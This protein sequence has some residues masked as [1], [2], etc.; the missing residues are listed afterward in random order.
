MARGNSWKT[1]NRTNAFYGRPS[2]VI[3]KR[4]L[5]IAPQFKA[6]DLY[7]PPFTHKKRFDEEGRWQYV[8]IERN[9]SPTGLRLLDELLRYLA[10]GS[11]DVSAFAEMR[12][13][14]LNELHTFI[15]I[16]TGM[17]GIRFRQLYQMWLVD[18][19][20]RYTDMSPAEVAKRS[21]L[22][23]PNNMYLALRREYNMSA[24]ERR[25]FLRKEGDLGR[26]KL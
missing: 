2:R 8:P 12:G 21:G 25:F 19:L 3:E 23:S 18:D 1:R 15:F 17:R 22:G 11:N 20:L 9:E 14:K 6:E 5:K 26:F 13:L 16:L 24:T 7:I 10:A 4:E